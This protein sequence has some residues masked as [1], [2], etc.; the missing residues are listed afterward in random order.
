MW[1]ELLEAQ[2]RAKNSKLRALHRLIPYIPD[3]DSKG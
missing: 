3:E 1:G 2:E